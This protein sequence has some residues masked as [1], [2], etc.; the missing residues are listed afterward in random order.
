MTNG[1]RGGGLAAEILRSIA[2][3]YGWPDYKVQ[4]KKLATVG[5]EKLRSFAG[6]YH[7]PNGP[8]LFLTVEKGRLLLTLPQGDIVEVFPESLT[9]FFNMNGDFPP[10]RF[11]RK[12]D[13]AVELTVGGMTARLRRLREV[14]KVCFPRV[15]Q[16]VCS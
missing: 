5:E 2:P 8:T 3:E 15:T 14:D 6:A 11:A 1:D 13:N 12:D 4:E 16:A 10:L 7:F 9:S